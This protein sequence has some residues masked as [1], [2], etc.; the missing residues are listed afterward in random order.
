[1]QRGATSTHG[2]DPAAFVGGFRKSCVAS[3]T[4]PSIAEASERVCDCTTRDPQT[5]ATSQY[6]EHS[7][8][9]KTY[10]PNPDFKARLE[11]AAAQCV[12]AECQ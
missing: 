10:A 12:A 2:L 3:C 4:R 7:L 6:L 5:H 9:P 11:Q 1:M 8:D